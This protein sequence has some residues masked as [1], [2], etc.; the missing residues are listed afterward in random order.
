VRYRNDA[1]HGKIVSIP[2][3]L[4]SAILKRCVLYEECEIPKEKPVLHLRMG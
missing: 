3:T 2:N 1:E 4:Y